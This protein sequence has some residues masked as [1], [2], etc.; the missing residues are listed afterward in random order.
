MSLA[1]QPNAVTA[2]PTAGPTGTRVL[3]GERP[4]GA[5]HLGHYFGTL[6]N[7]VALQRAGYDLLL[8]IADY[9][10][11]TDRDHPGDLTRVISDLVLDYLAVGLDPDRTTVFVHSAVPELHQLMLPFLSLVGMGELSRNPTVKEEIALS[12][13]S[14]VSGLML[15]YPVHQAADILFCKADLVP[16]GKDQ[17]PHLELT[18]SIARRFNDRYGLVFPL[19]EPLLGDVPVLLGLD[20]RK[21]GKS[22]GNG[23]ALRDRPDEVAAKIRAARTDSEREITFDPQRR[24]EVANLL[25]LGALCAGRGPAELA[26]DIGSGGAVALKQAVTDSVNAFLLPIHQRRGG[27]D[28]SDGRRVLERGTQRARALAV[29][30]LREVRTA[31]GMT[32]GGLF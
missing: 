24:P 23:I 15:T 16:V 30:T 31:M 6:A 18:R 19:P 2:A 22:R 9:Q 7:R 28:H 26:A 8:V 14:S 21:M 10:V 11:V 1:T 32:Y 27:F 13:R 12:G 5:L 3:T 4:T 20:G 25:R 17:L 29:D